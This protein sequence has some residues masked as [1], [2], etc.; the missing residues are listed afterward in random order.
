MRTLTS[1]AIA[2]TLMGAVSAQAASL[3]FATLDNPSDPTFNQLLGINN[4]GV[5]AGYFGSGGAGHPNQ[6]YTIAPPYTAFAAANQPGSTQTQATGINA[7]GVITGFWSSSNTGTDPNFG[8]IRWNNNGHYR[9][10]SVNNP[11]VASSPSVNQ[12]LGINPAEIAVGF[13]NDANGAP[14]GYSYTVKNGQ[15]APVTVG[16][17]V[18]DAATGIN[19][20]NLICGFYTDGTG[21]TK[22]FLKPVSGGSAV[23]FGV[24]GT[25]V[26]QFLGINSRGESVGFYVGADNLTHGLLYNP[27]NGQWQTIDD[28]SGANGTVLNGINDRGQVVGFY[29][30]AANNV[31]GMLIG[32]VP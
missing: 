25:T 1:L 29:T 21:A 15:F 23:R 7:G 20:N 27:A 14:H 32:G 13:Y 26:T 19:K 17:S 12:V 11:L 5:I 31:H 18:S 9:Y 8:F 3:T 4:K 24:P 10:L 22:G 16:G 6:G 28:A 30:D 2:A